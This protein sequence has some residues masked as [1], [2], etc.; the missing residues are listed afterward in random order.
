M[1]PQSAGSMPLHAARDLIPRRPLD[2]VLAL[3]LLS[4]PLAPFL[5]TF[6]SLGTALRLAIAAAVALLVV[7]RRIPLQRGP[8][9]RGRWLIVAFALFQII[10]LAG[11]ATVEYGLVRVVNW[12]MFMPLAFVAY[13]RRSQR[14]AIGFAAIAGVL[15]VVGVILQAVGV[16]GGTWAGFAL[17][18]GTP[19]TRYTSFLLNPNDLGLSMVLLGVVLGLASRG[20]PP[21]VRA[22]GLAAVTACGV[23]VSLTLSRGA[24]VALAGVFLY[25]LVVGLPRRRLVALASAALVGLL[26][27]PL[28]IP[29]TRESVSITL[30]S[31]ATIASGEDMSSTVRADR[32]SRLTGG[33]GTEVAES[34]ARNG[35]PLWSVSSSASAVATSEVSRDGQ[36][37]ARLTRKRDGGGGQRIFLASSVAAVEPGL[38]YTLTGHCRPQRVSRPCRA[39]MIFRNARG[40]PLSAPVG[41]T[42]MSVPGRWTRVTRTDGAPA[43]TVSA[44]VRAEIFDVPEGE[45]HYLDSFALTRG[46]SPA[47]AFPERGGDPLGLPPAVASPQRGTQGLARNGLPGWTASSS[48]RAVATSEVKRDGER[49][50]RLSRRRDGRGA[51]QIFLESEV[52]PI[53]PGQIYTLVGHCRAR[54]AGRPCRAIIIFLDARGTMLSG[55]VTPKVVS[56]SKQWT[57]MMV[58]ATA[59][60][61]AVSAKVR[62]EIF[63]VRKGETHYLDSFGVTR[64][65][66]PAATFPE[67][68]GDP[69]GLPSVP[70]L[71]A[72][73]QGGAGLPPATALAS[74]HVSGAVLGSLPPGSDTKAQSEGSEPQPPRGQGSL[75]SRD[76]TVPD[77][78]FGPG[79]G[80]Y[81]ERDDLSG[82][83][84]GDR[85]A[86]RKAQIR[87]TVDNGWL[88][89]F[90]EE[91]LIGTGLFLAIFATALRR[92]FS[93]R[94]TAYRALALT[95]GALL[96]AFG[97]RALSTDVLDV[98]PWNFVLWL[99]VGLAF[100]AASEDARRRTSAETA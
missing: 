34:Q 96:V 76:L 59:P 92:S 3:A 87:A 24:F 55:P 77:I 66:T 37:S 23:V 12:T 78:V 41:P 22:A 6:S 93:A 48:A 70:P 83:E 74:A 98:N 60:L 80:R 53:S 95:T 91:G 11:A 51:S 67:Q 47:T 13:D 31:L 89:L 43:G 82:F 35:L 38:T 81:A 28:A 97:A 86:R 44:E 14:T 84:L 90:L 49:S 25:L 88:K 46:R 85:E 10:P 62:G 20:R 58:T 73:A 30:G 33:G 64:G 72:S 63:K 16:L 68:G 42:V 56:S 19:A 40:R 21:A 69:L 75:D 2:L 54:G 79:F 39:M 1:S 26:A 36:Q 99:V 7:A 100:A 17:S 8:L 29:T 71:A 50:A 27:I 4:L 57:P 61:G 94:H 15:L 45:T 52:E 18:D 9:G 32:W 65:P 5:N